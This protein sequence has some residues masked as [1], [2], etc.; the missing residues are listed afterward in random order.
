MLTHLMDMY[1]LARLLYYIKKKDTKQIVT[2]T[3]SMHTDNYVKF[4]TKYMKE[5]KL[6]YQEDNTESKRIKRLVSLPADIVLY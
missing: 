3:G 6:L 2:Y 5:S 4:F 1:L